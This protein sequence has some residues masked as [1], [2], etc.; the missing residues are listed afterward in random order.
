MACTMVWFTRL[1]ERSSAMVVETTQTAGS[2]EA[3]QGLGWQSTEKKD[4]RH[5]SLPPLPVGG[6]VDLGVNLRLLLLL[7]QHPPRRRGDEELLVDAVAQAVGNTACQWGGKRV[8]GREVER[9]EVSGR[10]KGWKS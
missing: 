3:R 5:D 1:C 8:G 9:S 2:L 4:P 7:L 6:A 10:G